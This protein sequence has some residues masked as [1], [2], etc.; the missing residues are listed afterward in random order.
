M[1]VILSFLLGIAAVI[2]AFLIGSA[3]LVW[4]LNNKRS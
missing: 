4:A 2:F 1:C 3:V